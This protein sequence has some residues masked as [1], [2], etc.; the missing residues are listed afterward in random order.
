MSSTLL[1]PQ[2]LDASTL[3]PK[4]T[5]EIFL[6]IGIE[7]Q[8]DSGGTATAA[9]LYTI[10]RVDES[11][12]LFGAASSLHK[13][14]KAVLDRGAGPVKVVASAKGTAPVLAE[15]QAA[16][17]DRLGAELGERRLRQAS[18][19]MAEIIEVLRERSSAAD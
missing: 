10:T 16:W 7:G 2:V 17:A 5:S 14:V 3:I 19:L 12:G 13:I 6:P 4:L 1:D 15:R 11:A 9:V 18:A 8:A